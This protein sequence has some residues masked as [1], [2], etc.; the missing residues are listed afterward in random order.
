MDKY[1]EFKFACSQV[2]HMGEEDIISITVGATSFDSSFLQL[3]TQFCRRKTDFT[4]LCLNGP[5]RF[6][7][8]M[9]VNFLSLRLFLIHLSL[10]LLF[11]Y[12][13]GIIHLSQIFS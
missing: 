2:K 6:I 11:T 4:C 5:I 3:R 9:Q 13:S 12:L 7:Y 10:R 8:S 1:P